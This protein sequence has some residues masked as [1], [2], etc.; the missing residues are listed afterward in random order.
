MFNLSISQRQKSPSC[1]KVSN[2]NIFHK[3]YYQSKTKQPDQIVFKTKKISEK[4]QRGKEHSFAEA[5]RSLIAVS[6]II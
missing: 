1:F 5:M 3:S 4:V 2:K 6:L